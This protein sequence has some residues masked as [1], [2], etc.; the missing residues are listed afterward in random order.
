MKV[1]KLVADCEF[2]AADIEDAL[3]KLRDHF[4]AV[5]A[6]QDS[7]L[8]KGGEIQVEPCES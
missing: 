5:V 4:A 7:D 1:F 3:S 2:Y 6:G 8:I